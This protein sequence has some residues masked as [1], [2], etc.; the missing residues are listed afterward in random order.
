MKSQLLSLA[1]VV[2]SVFTAVLPV[3]SAE[4]HLVFEPK[5]NALNQHVVLLAGDEEY[6]SE[7]ALPMLGQILSRH[8]FKATVLFSLG[9]DGKVDPRNGASLSHS[10]A[11]DEADAIVMSLR[12]RKWG[13]EAMARF[14]K[15]LNRGVP[16]IALRTST[17]A[18]NFPGDS[19]WTKYSWRSNVKGWEKGFGRQVLGETW[20]SHH[21]KHKKE[22][23]RTHVEKA[24]ASHPILK[25]VGEIFCTSDVYEAAPLEP[26]TIL[27]RG[28]VTESFD[29]KSKGVPEKNNPMQP[30]AWVREFDNEG[31]K[32]NRIF[33]TTMG[34]SSDLA[35]ESLRRLVINA[36]Y[37][38]LELEVPEKA[39][40]DVKG[41]NPT[42]YS[43]DGFK[44]GLKP[45]DFIPGAE[46][47]NAA[48]LANTVLKKKPKAKPK[49]QPKP[50]P[51]AQAKPKEEKK[52]SKKD[53]A[54]LGVPEPMNPESVAF[55]AKPAP[56]QLEVKQGDNIV[57]VGAGMGSRMSHFGHF[58]TEVFL[59]FPDKDLT[60]RN[61][62]DEG[63]TPG[64]RP[65]PGR[66]QDAQ[67]AFPGARELLPPELQ[68]K[69]SPVGHF[70]T[71]DQWLTRLGA[72]TIIAFF[73]FNS[74]F[75]GAEDLSRFKK[76][77]EAFVQHTLSR[78]YN[79]ES[80][81][82]LALVSPT[83]IQDIS[84]QFS[85]PDGKTENENLK[86]YTEAMREI[87]RVNGAL[88]IDT[89]TPSREWF[90]K[91]EQTYT[92]DGALL[93]DAGYR[94]LAPSLTEELFG[95]SDEKA[96]ASREAIHSAVMEKNWAWLNDFKIPNGVHVYGRRYNPFGPEN[97][98]YELEKTRQMTT[99][100]DQAIWA[101]LKGKEFDLAAEDAKTLKLPPVETNYVPSVKNGTV[102]YRP[103]RIVETKIKVPEGYKIE[104]FA[105]EETFPD[106]K[107]PVQL[108][109][110][111]KGRLWVATMESYP[112]YKIGDPL[113][114]DKLL[115]LEDTDNDGFADKQT[116]FA[117]DLHIPIGFEISHDGVYVSQSGSL[118]RL[119]DTDGDDHYDVRE[120]MLSGFDDHDTHHAISAFCAD[121]SGAFIMGEG[122][123]L[124]SNV[125]SV[126]GPS[127]G[128]NGGFYRYSPQRKQIL[129]YTQFRIPNPW[130]VAYDDYGQD[131]FLHTSGTK[132]SWMTPGTVKVRYGANMDAPD[133]ITSNSVRPTSGVEFVSSR[134]FPDE[135]QGDVLI[136]NNIGYLGA[137]QHRVK[138]DGTGFTT[139][140]VHDLFVSED[141]NFRPTDL[142]FAPDGSLFVVDWHNALI[143][144]M[145]HS[146]RDPMRDHT[147][148]RIY[149]VTYPGRPL[150]KPAKVD[151]ASIAELLENLT[152]H[153]YRTRYRTRRELRERD[154]DEVAAAAA[155]W[156]AKQKDERHKLEALWVTWGADRIDAGLLGELLNSKDH[157]IRSAAVRVAR[158]N[159]HKL[160]N[161][162][163]ILK[164]AAGD[165]HGRV[166]LEAIGAASYLQE[167]EGRE[168]LE[169]A[170]A[171]GIDNHMKQSLEF[172]E[173]V[174]T[175]SPVKGE[176]SLR[177]SAPA[178]L[179][180]A[181]G[182][183]FKK[184]AEIYAREGHCG[185]CHQSN[186]MGLPDAGF[187][188][189]SRTKW[190]TGS[191]ERLIKLT[192]NG[193]MG[194]IEVK[195]K[196]YPG[197]V[198]MTAFGGLLNDKDIASVLTYVRNSFGNK[199]SPIQP[200][201]V[202][203]VRAA[204]KDKVGLW[205]ADELLKMYPYE[206]GQSSA[207]A[208]AGNEEEWEA[209]TPDKW[210]NFQGKGIRDEWQYKDGI[211]TLTKK[212]GGDIIT[213]E[214]FDAFEMVLEYKISKGGNSGLMFH[215]T[216]DEKTPWRTG[217]EIQIQDH[218]NGQDPQRAG[219]LYQLYEA[220]TDAA[221]PYTEWNELR[222][223]VTPEKNTHWLNG[224][225]YFE[226]QKGSED[227][228]KRVAASKFTK[229]PKFGKPMK[230]HIALQDHGN[231][232]SFR[233]I[234]IR[235]LK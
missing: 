142:E 61:L 124:H 25:S 103:G 206:D 97:Y 164:K 92:V 84:S 23:C 154:G 87:A 211:L 153:E 213:V 35:D 186:G 135:V 81:P 37:W 176:S 139:E 24:N 116:V 59:R 168:I 187:P 4:D 217:P 63:N 91:G 111:N 134:H 110:D 52:E 227:W 26:S 20:V 16:I 80:V 160:D 130:G 30:V 173:G 74:S 194:P 50:A 51:K 169:I 210:R 193:L 93:N 128:T 127:R 180:K 150:V 165:E 13:D 123:F 5:G 95:K 147:H 43:F 209:L 157:R 75:G 208:P 66:H 27:L 141:L 54:K 98:P 101:A 170:K 41:F 203:K 112:H 233:N 86:L 162:A 64:F 46:A 118:I 204:T 85:V 45:V 119:Q 161:L 42:F 183:L 102:D 202:A 143:G 146:A 32:N 175:G 55:A 17:H 158:F 67:Y 207:A 148:G 167:E 108:A 138:E 31:E 191:P 177:I 125:E 166:R 72:D 58:E 226:Y 114:K 11:L 223:K 185:T 179:S 1:L 10:E 132:F 144:H 228:N 79:G 229:F 196:K 68:A 199:A 214:Q 231:E 70:E 195:G 163:D 83:A 100:R 181:D 94:K 205:M 201:Q 131:F 184:G 192:L 178:H 33:T 115:I 88:F 188:P 190:A 6:R 38:G 109:F 15:A 107:N 133:L 156:A 220:K 29:P 76:E 89:F 9:E 39:D 14:E 21:G 174:F 215:V 44:Y 234:K 159:E 99:I 222:L 60:I 172:A 136:N 189:I 19:K 106:L 82:Q 225:K 219:W 7:E 47:F 53:N 232:V 121:P 171:K 197:Q 235:R 2:S 57:L 8:G 56:E 122:V 113:P 126:Y 48:P 36:V 151:G 152:L 96:A 12:F 216:E 73:G 230:G 104:L 71:P 90:E 145:Q 137:K 105:S 224:V 78:K 182:N 140:Y 40:V 149:R 34:A 221:K 77:L 129:R 198:P 62:C 69:S 18:F 117:D 120:V 218:L 200:E 65:H 28:E 212:G 22:G 155:A 49:A 3:W